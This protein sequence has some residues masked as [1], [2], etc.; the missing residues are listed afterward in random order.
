M[1]SGHLRT[2]TMTKITT[3]VVVAAALISFLSFPLSPTV[4][5]IAFTT[6]KL[7]SSERTIVSTSSTPPTRSASTTLP[8]TPMTIKLTTTTIN[9]NNDF[10][11]I[12][13]P[14]LASFAVSQSRGGSNCCNVSSRRRIGRR[15]NSLIRTSLHTTN[16]NNVNSHRLGMSEGDDISINERLGSSVPTTVFLASSSSSSTSLA[17]REQSGGGGGNDND[18]K[19]GRNDDDDDDDND[20][21][22]NDQD[23]KDNVDDD[24]TATTLHVHESDEPSLS[25]KVQ[26]TLQRWVDEIPFG[27]LFRGKE[28]RDKLP[29]ILVEDSN[30]LFYDIFLIVNLSLSISI[31]VTH[32]LDITY[33]PIAFNEGCFFSSLWILAGLY[34]GSFLY[35]SIDGHYDPMEDPEKAGPKAAAALAFN[36]YINAINLRLVAALIGAWVQHRQVG[37][38]SIDGFSGEAMEQLIPLEITCGIVLMPLWRALHSSYTPRI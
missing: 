15:M 18:N 8:M 7:K 37:L 10:R 26:N 34:H 1:S 28:G 31:W 32:R 19:S 25:S 30:V 14:S 35:S 21:N 4:S 11:Q 24:L 27:Y 6:S 20:N 33:L 2:S 36:T 3:S 23:I 13:H 12:H 9:G 17:F 5:V 38:L 29:P 22:T 16:M